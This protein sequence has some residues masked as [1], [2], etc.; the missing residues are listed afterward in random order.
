[1]CNTIFYD[2]YLNPEMVHIT[3]QKSTILMDIQHEI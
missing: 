3:L 1:M 2:S